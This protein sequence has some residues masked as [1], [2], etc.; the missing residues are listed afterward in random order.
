MTR[1]FLIRVTTGIYFDMKNNNRFVSKEENRDVILKVM[2]EKVGH[3]AVLLGNM[4]F[5]KYDHEQNT[6]IKCLCACYDII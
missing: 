5:K 4:S 1:L 2:I 3:S 6:T